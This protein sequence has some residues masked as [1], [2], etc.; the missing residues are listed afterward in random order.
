MPRVIVVDDEGAAADALSRLLKLDGYEVAP[1]TS[2]KLARA[3]IEGEA[4]DAV[5]T[6]LEMPEL[7]GVEIVRTAQ[8]MKLAAPVFVVSAYAGS[9]VA[10]NSLVAGARRVFAKPLD[11]D[12]LSEALAEAL[13]S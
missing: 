7:H 12:E 6:D 1:F 2:A 9:A 5:I 11:Y 8:R 13:S 10:N 3:A 4:F